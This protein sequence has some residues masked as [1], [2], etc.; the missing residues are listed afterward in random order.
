MKQIKKILFLLTIVVLLASTVLT[1]VSANVSN[2]KSKQENE[3]EKTGEMSGK[4]EVI[5]ATLSPTGEQQ[6]LYVVNRFDI[7]KEGTI[8]DYGDYTSVRNLTDMTEVT[9]D[10]NKVEFSATDEK[11]YYQGNMEKTELPWNIDVTYYLDGEK[12]SPEQLAGKEGTIKIEVDAKA[13][14]EHGKTFFNNYMLQVTLPF[15]SETFSNIQAPDGMVANA[16]KTQQITFTLMPEKEKTFTVEADTDNFEFDGIEISGVPSSMS[17]ED[18]ETDEMTGDIRTLSDAIA[19]LNTGVSDLVVGVREMND[20]ASELVNGSAQYRGGIAELDGSSSELIGGSKEIE[21]ALQ[22]MNGSLS[23]VDVDTSQQDQLVEGL[24]QLSAGLKEMKDGLQKLKDN[25]S[26]AYQALDGAMNG[27]PSN[28]TKEE[29]NGLQGMKAPQFTEKE[30]QAL[31]EA[32]IEQET[33]QKLQNVQSSMEQ[34]SS[35]IGKLA[36]VYEK[37][38]VAKGTY[39]GTQ[40]KPGAK[41]AL[42][43]VVG[44]LE[45]TIAGLNEMTANVDTMASEISSVSNGMEGL[46]QLKDGIASLTKEY[47]SFHTGLAEYTNGVK[48]LSN[49]YSDIH[50]GI[51]EFDHGVSELEEG[52]VELKDGTQELHDSTKDMPQEMTEEIDEMISQYDKSD[53][54]SVSFVS[55]KNE[56][57]DHVQF[58]IQTKSIEVDESKE[59]EPEKEEKSSFWE[60]FKA[61]FS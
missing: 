52:V 2:D 13:N 25:Y 4:D 5:Y 35:T 47:G 59:E 34:V 60:K 61:L 31:Q 7:V 23:D 30:M 22:S 40:D 41:A 53:F 42:G 37:A 49:S 57:V 38:Q 24:K 48:E 11:F 58:V 29:L 12:I 39:F 19:D 1:T 14:G 44:S 16:G 36:T 56:Q 51:N 21:N 46:Q 28:L 17:I 55:E 10:G 8:V 43:A 27:I 50:A 45:E 26:T 18:P 3:R 33:L 20:G 15:D 6:E 32:G 9:L 54:D